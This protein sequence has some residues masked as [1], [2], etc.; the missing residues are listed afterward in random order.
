MGKN[1]LELTGMQSTKYG[2][3]EKYFVELVRHCKEDT[4]HFVYDTEPASPDYM[5]DIARGGGIFHYQSSN[6]ILNSLV[7]P[8]LI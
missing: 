7:L 1:I 5:N 6:E 4:F 8:S 2:G 3:I